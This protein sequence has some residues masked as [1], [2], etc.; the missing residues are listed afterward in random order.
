MARKRNHQVPA[1]KG[2]G[3]H[4][5]SKPAAPQNLSIYEQYRL[6]R[7]VGSVAGIAKAGNDEC[8]FVE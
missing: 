6:L 1:R 3:V 5:K 2:Q 8:I 7:S 4:S